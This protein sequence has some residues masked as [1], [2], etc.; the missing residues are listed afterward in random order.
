MI[1]SAEN[2]VLSSDD[3]AAIGSSLGRTAFGWH[4]F[5]LLHQAVAQAFSDEYGCELMYFDIMRQ[6]CDN[7]EVAFK[8]PVLS[9]FDTYRLGRMLTHLDRIAEAE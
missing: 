9:H 5:D 3:K 6:A 7:A 4:E 8:S 2:I 1:F